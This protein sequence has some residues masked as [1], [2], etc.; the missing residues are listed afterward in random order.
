MDIASGIVV[1]VLLWW[2]VF[3]M[4]LPVGVK[5]AETVETGHD[6]GAPEK[7]HLWKKALAATVIAGALWFAVDWVIA[8]ELISF[9]DMAKKL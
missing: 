4:S 1:Y 8:A 5:Q 6:A 2:W 9:R 3:F 7:P